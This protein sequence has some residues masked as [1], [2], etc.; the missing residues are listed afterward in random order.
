MTSI[1]MMQPGDSIGP[2]PDETKRRLLAE[3]GAGVIWMTPDQLKS[4][5]KSKS[6][7]LEKYWARYV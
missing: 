4:Y 3:E 7:G 6:V 5:L 1:L 2:D